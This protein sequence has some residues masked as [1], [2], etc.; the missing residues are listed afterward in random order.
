MYHSTTYVHHSF[1]FMPL[2]KCALKINQCDIDQNLFDILPHGFLLGQIVLLGFPCACSSISGA[3]ALSRWSDVAHWGRVTHVCVSELNT[4]GSG[5]GLSPERH[6]AIIWTSAG[7]LLIGPLRALNQS[8]NIF[9]HE[10]ALEN[11]VC[12]MAS[13]LSRPQCV[14]KLELT[15]HFNGL[16]I[17]LATILG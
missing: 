1:N 3:L 5:N 17:T 11:V 16:C 6:Q 9:N 13:I 14:K 4:I 8:S 2:L 7:M 12:Q 15:H 10:N